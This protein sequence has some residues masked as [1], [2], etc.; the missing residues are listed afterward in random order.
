MD[1]KP[2]IYV[3]NLLKSTDVKFDPNE[4][5]IISRILS[6][7][8][9]SAMKK[10]NLVDA[11]KK[12]LKIF[13]MGNTGIWTNID[14]VCFVARDSYS[15]QLRLLSSAHN[16]KVAE[17]I[18]VPGYSCMI[19]ERSSLINIKTGEIRVYDN[20]DNIISSYNSFH[21][22]VQ[23]SISLIHKS[24]LKSG[25]TIPL[26]V[27][28]IVLGFLFLNSIKPGEFNKLSSQ[29][30]SLLCLVQLVYEALLSDYVFARMDL[31]FISSLEL[32][33]N[34]NQILLSSLKND[35]EQLSLNNLKKKMSFKIKGLVKTDFLL[36]HRKYV[37][38]ILTA[39]NCI[40]NISSYN[41]VS[42]SLL[43]CKENQLTSEITFDGG[44]P[45]D[46]ESNTQKM[47]LIDDVQFHIGEN[48][49]SF[50]HKYENIT[51]GLLYSV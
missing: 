6:L 11:S 36:S 19:D 48:K 18:L 50:S 34:K 44:A 32:V 1:S 30:Y 31:G 51:D 29:D 14:R 46:L 8:N 2:N 25:I 7:A 4:S 28:G 21:K 49:I 13:E 33:E 10:I 20:I 12:L 39:L 47:N 5:F 43:S 9:T 42:L 3:F 41:E 27:N 26:K 35:L 38:S 45:I 17:S 24:N 40:R 22:K 15:C 37:V 23:R 16:E